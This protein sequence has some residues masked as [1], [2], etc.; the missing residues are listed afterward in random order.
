MLK[1]IEHIGRTADRLYPEPGDA[2][3]AAWVES[4]RSSAEKTTAGYTFSLPTKPGRSSM[5]CCGC[6]ASRSSIRARGWIS[7]L[8]RSARHWKG[9]R[10][11]LGV[12]S[13]PSSGK[14]PTPPSDFP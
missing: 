8:T 10:V 6:C 1:L 3:R 13:A 4:F 5:P 9:T 11:P 7:R 2:R 14:A 12:G